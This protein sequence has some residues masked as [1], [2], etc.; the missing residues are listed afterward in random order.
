M[1]LPTNQEMITSLE[2]ADYQENN[3]P[4][5][6]LVPVKSPG[7]FDWLLQ[8]CPHCSCPQWQ[9]LKQKCPHWSAHTGKTWMSQA[10]FAFAAQMGNIN[11]EIYDI[12]HLRSDI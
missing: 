4:V 5:T 1:N 3:F 9:H 6:F 8:K 10:P 7:F 12:Q 2:K 11:L